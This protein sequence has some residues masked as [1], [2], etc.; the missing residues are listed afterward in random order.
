MKAVNRNAED[1]KNYEMPAIL[2][3]SPSL[4]K[5]LR[6]LAWKMPLFM[7]EN[8]AAQ[9]F[10]WLFGKKLPKESFFQ[11]VPLTLPTKKPHSLHPL[12]KQ[13]QPTKTTK[14]EFYG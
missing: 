10:V 6:F 12:N 4:L 9:L 3:I 14:K 1:K 2:Y 11:S 8:V 7:S 13:N 5:F